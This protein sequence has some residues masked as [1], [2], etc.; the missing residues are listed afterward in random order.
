MAKN[1][2]DRIIDLFFDEN[3]LGRRGEKLIVRELRKLTKSGINGKILRN[4]Y[5]PKENDETSEVDIV[6]ITQKGVFVIESKNYSGWIFGDEK[7]L[8]WTAMFQNRLK[9][10]FYNP[11]KQN[12]THIKWLAHYLECDVSFFSYI[13]FSNRCEL[14]KIQ[15]EHQ[16]IKVIQC[17]Q[18]VG[19]VQEAWNILEDRL[20]E[21]Q[22]RQVYLKMKKL[23]KTD[24]AVKQ[25]H[26]NRIRMK[27][28]EAES[29]SEKEQNQEAIQEAVLEPVKQNFSADAVTEQ[30]DTICPR[31]GSLLVERIARKG[32][33]TGE[34][35]YGCSNYPKCRYHRYANTMI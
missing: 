1:F 34:H 33:H 7:S 8:K 20:S 12:S 5:I 35:F 25:E 6:F 30:N 11:I 32:E 18:L 31:C 22:L 4:L 15:V 14:K 21:E 28:A 24:K 27:Y 2:I 29:L 23:T 19:T 16:D 10:R 3:W 17:H 9:N 26:I 13:V